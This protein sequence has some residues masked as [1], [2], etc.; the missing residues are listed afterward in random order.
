L[1]VKDKI[2]TQIDTSNTLFEVVSNK[3]FS[4]LFPCVEDACRIV[5][6]CRKDNYAASI[7]ARAV[8]DCDAHLL[9]LNVTGDVTPNGDMIVELRVA[10]N[11]AERIIRSLYRYDYDVILVEH[12]DANDGE[13][14]RHRIGELMRYIEI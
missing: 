4:R 13:T 1:S 9:N 10:V 6:A 2:L 5:I 14:M 11:N 3:D 7:V 12:E 8:E